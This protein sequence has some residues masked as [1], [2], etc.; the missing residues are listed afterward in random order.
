[1]EILLRQMDLWYKG[2]PGHLLIETEMAE[3][4]KILPEY[5]GRHLLQIGGP[6]EFLLF[7]N[8]PIR[9]RVRLSPEYS[10]VF[11][12]PSVQSSFYKLPFFPES[13]DVILLPHVLEFVTKPEA[14][15]KEVYTVLAPEGYLILLGFNPI[16]FWGLN[17]WL[18]RH[19]HLPWRGHFWSLIR[20]KHWLIQQDFEIV[21]TRAILYRP[22]FTHKETLKK[23]LFLEAMGRLCWS[24]M[25]GVYI[26]VAKKKQF[27]LTPLRE[28]LHPAPLA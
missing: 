4:A 24:S 28:H 7:H 23:L 17:K 20:V 8:S 6:S 14:I 15:L 11:S 25:G 26:I 13:I 12:G 18:R 27:G 19:Q 2:I 3:L 22:P 9:H 5:N 10:P 16:S 1:M 21:D